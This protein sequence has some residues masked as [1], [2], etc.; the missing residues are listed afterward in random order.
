MDPKIEKAHAAIMKARFQIVTDRR[1]VFFGVVMMNLKPIAAEWL[2]TAGVDGRHLFYNPGFINSLT[3]AQV[4][5]VIC[6]ETSHVTGFHFERQGGR[7]VER[8]NIATDMKINSGLKDIKIELPQGAVYGEYA[9]QRMTCEQVY[10]TLPKS[11]GKGGKGKPGQGNDPGRCGTFLTPRDEN[12]KELTPSE[13]RKV[14]TAARGIIEEASRMAKS[15]GSMPQFI[16]AMIHETDN[17]PLPWHEILR[18]WATQHIKV[19]YTWR[20]PNRRM[21]GQGLYLPSQKMEGTGEVV[22]GIDTSGSISQEDLNIFA[23]NVQAIM[24]DCEPERVHVVTCDAQ[25]HT[26]ATFERGDEIKIKLVGRGGTDFRP[27]F[28]WV[29][30][31]GL[32]PLCLIYFTDLQGSFP[33]DPG[34]PTIWAATCDLHIPFGEK[35]MVNL[36]ES[37]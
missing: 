14:A 13:A 28:A 1:L 12:G 37:A 33:A 4:K 25:V 34:Y 6:H 21:L 2:P 26:V 10:N 11:A 16:E 19:D 32:N 18:R 7:E 29:R 17:E 20:R 9:H 22:V 30:E 5:G 3:P 24:D 15:Q 23:K 8:W 31:K 36:E 27:V 35:V